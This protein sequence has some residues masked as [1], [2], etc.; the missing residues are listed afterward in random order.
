VKARALLLS[1]HEMG[2]NNGDDVGFDDG[3]HSSLEL[4]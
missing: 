2:C 1:L 3:M 4:C